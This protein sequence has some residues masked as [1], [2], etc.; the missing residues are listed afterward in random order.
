VESLALAFI[1]AIIAIILALF[2][3]MKMRLP[4]VQPAPEPV[5]A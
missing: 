4:R 5:P 3:L 1:P 2:A